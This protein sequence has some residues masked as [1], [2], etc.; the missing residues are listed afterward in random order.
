MADTPI[1]YDTDELIF[2]KDRI[3]S[4]DLLL[5]FEVIQQVRDGEFVSV[6]S[7]NARN[8]PYKKLDGTVTNVASA[9]DE[10]F[11]RGT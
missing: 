7:I 11:N 5:G 10:L 2:V 3:G 1:T 4:E 6:T 8:I 9:L